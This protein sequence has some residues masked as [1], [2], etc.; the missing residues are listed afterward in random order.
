[1]AEKR[2]ITAVAVG[3]SPQRDLLDAIGRLGAFPWIR[4]A[5]MEPSGAAPTAVRERLRAQE[6]ACVQHL[7]QLA[8]GAGI[9]YKTTTTVN[10]L[11][12]LDV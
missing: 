4:P 9:L 6:D 10:G 3:Y 1:L 11:G 12:K 5:H 8:Q 7:Q 2:D